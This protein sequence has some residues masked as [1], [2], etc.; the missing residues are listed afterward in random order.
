[1]EAKSRGPKGRRLKW[2]CAVMSDAGAVVRFV[3]ETE[4]HWVSWRLE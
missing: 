4:P 2:N 1:L 3:R